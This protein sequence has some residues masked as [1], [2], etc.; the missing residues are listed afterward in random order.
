MPYLHTALSDKLQKNVEIDP[1]DDIDAF[2][3]TLGS[4]PQSRSTKKTGA[5]NDGRNK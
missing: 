3:K 4:Q 1:H 5:Q 2:F